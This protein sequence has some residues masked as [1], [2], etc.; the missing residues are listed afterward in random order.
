MFLLLKIFPQTVGFANKLPSNQ[1]F[2]KRVVQFETIYPIL[3]Y[4]QHFPIHGRS[5]FERGHAVMFTLS[6]L[7][8]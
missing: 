2:W 5:W 4:S 3:F 1:W 7:Y 8:W 6:R